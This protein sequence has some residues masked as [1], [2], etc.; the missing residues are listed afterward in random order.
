MTP[1]VNVARGRSIRS[2]VSTA[3]TASIASTVSIADIE[4]TI[5]GG[6]TIIV[7]GGKTNPKALH[8]VLN[9]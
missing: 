2:I 7:V 1:R 9:L 5:T 3:S 8:L 6:T 4:D